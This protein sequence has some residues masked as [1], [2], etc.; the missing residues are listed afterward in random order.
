MGVVSRNETD[1]RKS[2]HIVR[3]ESE[4]GTVVSEQ[5]KPESKVLPESMSDGNQS[6]INFR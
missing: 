1:D 6:M 4:D 5:S 2:A 3:D